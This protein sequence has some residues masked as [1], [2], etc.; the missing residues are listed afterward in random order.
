MAADVTTLGAALLATVVAARPDRSGRRSFGLYRLEV[1]ASLLA[2][3]IMLAVALFVVLSALSRFGTAPEIETGPILVVGVLGLVVNV[4]VMLLLRAGAGESLN[5]RGAY[6][7]V[8]AD[9]VGSVGVI[10]AALLVAATGSPLWDTLIALAIGVF[11][12]AR[13][14]MLGREVFAVLAQETPRHLD[15]GSVDADLQ[16]LEDVTEVHDLHLWTLTSGMDVATAHLRIRAGADPHHVLDHAQRVLREKH[17][18]D[19][20]TL[21][22][23]PAEHRT[24]DESAW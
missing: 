7:E 17:G 16:D 4:V 8:V 11:V 10:L 20:C 19:H 22:I 23:E 6:L 15:P 18:L 2:V 21:Q 3:V 9:T 14:V 1:F 12:A 24:E 5:L 13:A